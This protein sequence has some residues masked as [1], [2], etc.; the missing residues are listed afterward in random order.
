[1]LGKDLLLEVKSMR[2][3]SKPFQRTTDLD[4]DDEPKEQKIGPKKGQM[5]ELIGHDGVRFLKIVLLYKDHGALVRRITET[6]KFVLKA[7]TFFSS[8]DSQTTF[9][10]DTSD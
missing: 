7:G 2:N 10:V 1:V 8:V 3:V 4:L 6:N 9:L 5:Y